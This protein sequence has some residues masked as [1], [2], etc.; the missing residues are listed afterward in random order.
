MITKKQL[1]LLFYINLIFNIRGEIPTYKD[2][3]KMTGLS[4][5]SAIAQRI[6]GLV[7]KGYLIKTKL[8]TGNLKIT[9]RGKIDDELLRLYP[10]CGNLVKNEKPIKKT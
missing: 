1:E 10:M 7:K 9:D 5:K 4:S 3:L 8:G 6:N 2:M